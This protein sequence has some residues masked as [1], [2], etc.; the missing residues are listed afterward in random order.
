MVSHSFLQKI[1]PK[2][3]HNQI[4]NPQESFWRERV[5][6]L[7][8]VPR[9]KLSKPHVIVSFYRRLHG[10]THDLNASWYF[11][12]LLASRR[13]R[14]AKKVDS[15]AFFGNTQRVITSPAS[16]HSGR[17][18]APRSAR[19]AAGVAFQHRAEMAQRGNREAK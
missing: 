19:L 13:L 8:R 3:R 16:L 14:H 10:T 2:N 15:E 6:L 5:G 11:S 7:V 18:R 9:N 4:S 17:L 1:Q 12:Q